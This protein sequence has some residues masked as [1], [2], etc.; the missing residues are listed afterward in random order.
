MLPGLEMFF[1]WVLSDT[2]HPSVSNEKLLLDYHAFPGRISFNISGRWK[3]VSSMVHLY[4]WTTSSSSIIL[5]P[6]THKMRRQY[7]SCSYPKVKV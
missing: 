3:I 7:I 4:L 1:R 6:P 5:I 2:T